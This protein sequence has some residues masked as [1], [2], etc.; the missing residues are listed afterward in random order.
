VHSGA[1]FS[2]VGRVAARPPI[3]GL[4]LSPCLSA[5]ADLRG[6]A[7][8]RRPALTAFSETALNHRNT[9]QFLKNSKIYEDAEHQVPET[10]SF[11]K[12]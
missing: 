10:A 2:L 5:N 8:G 9:V 4:G 6:G 1:F 12:R 3:V 7:F 11:G